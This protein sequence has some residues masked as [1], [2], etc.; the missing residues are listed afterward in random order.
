MFTI[1]PHRMSSAFRRELNSPL[2]LSDASSPRF[3]FADR[4]L[5]MPIREGRKR[6]FQSPQPVGPTA[7][8]VAQRE[9]RA[10]EIKALITAGMQASSRNWGRSL[11]KPQLDDPNPGMAT[12]RKTHARGRSLVHVC[13]SCGDSSS[14]RG[15]RQ[16]RKGRAGAVKRPTGAGRPTGQHRAT[17][18][19]NALRRRNTA[20]A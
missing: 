19:G 12:A 2:P 7:L 9:P 4:I 10:P 11:R 6:R 18:L 16:H 13:R 5:Q 15:P 20:V 3:T 1:K 17:P 14:Y 8:L